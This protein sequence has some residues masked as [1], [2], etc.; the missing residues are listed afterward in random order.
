MKSQR[1]RGT[2][3]FVAEESWGWPFRLCSAAAYIPM[4]SGY[5]SQRAYR[6]VA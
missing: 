1:G 3:V 6:T 4:A 2:K 5:H